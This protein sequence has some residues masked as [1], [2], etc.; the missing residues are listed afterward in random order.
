MIWSCWKAWG[1]KVVFSKHLNRVLQLLLIVF[2][3]SVYKSFKFKNLAC[4]H[5]TSS[6]GDN[7]V[8]YSVPVYIQ[9]GYTSSGGSLSSPKCIKYCPVFCVHTIPLYNLLTPLVPPRWQC[10]DSLR[11]VYIQEVIQV[12]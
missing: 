8:T 6:L 2:T 3:Y 5:P 7:V 1:P 11:L 4:S 12:R 10:Y 9:G